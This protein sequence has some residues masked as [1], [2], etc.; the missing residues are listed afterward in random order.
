MG[1]D[2]PPGASAAPNRCG[3]SPP[4]VARSALPASA[5]TARDAGRGDRV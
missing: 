2:P 3:S 4:T 5:A 1:K